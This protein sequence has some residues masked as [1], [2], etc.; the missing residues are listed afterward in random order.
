MACRRCRGRRWSCWGD[1]QGAGSEGQGEWQD[2]LPRCGEGAAGTLRCGFACSVPGRSAAIWRPVRRRA[3]PRYPRSRAARISRPSARMACAS[4][5]PTGRSP[6]ACPR[7]TIRAGAVGGAV[8]SRGVSWM[9]RFAVVETVGRGVRGGRTDS[10]GCRGVPEIWR[11]LTDVSFRGVGDG[12]SE[13]EN[14]GRG[15][16][17]GCGGRL[18][19]PEFPCGRARDPPRS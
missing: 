16:W 2:L 1:R 18:R 7:A 11:H 10:G 3:A 15:R 5:P 17:T 9:P 12:R 8:G 6:P 14:C 4:R 19:S 13:G